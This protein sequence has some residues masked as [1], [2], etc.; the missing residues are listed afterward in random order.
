MSLPNASPGIN[1]PCTTAV[2]GERRRSSWN[3][4]G[5][6]QRHVRYI[7]K[8]NV[9]VRPRVLTNALSINCNP[10]YCF[11]HRR[12]FPPERPDGFHPIFRLDVRRVARPGVID[13]PL[14]GHTDSYPG[15]HAV[16]HPEVKGNRRTQQTGEG[17]GRNAT[18][19]R[20]PTTA[21]PAPISR[22]NANPDPDPDGKP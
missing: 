19:R 21:T 9:S 8:R 4:R 11:F 2:R 14:S 5:V 7:L 13:D 20:F 1:G 6:R 22:L 17:I 12:F 3:P 16:P 18:I 15:V 10:R